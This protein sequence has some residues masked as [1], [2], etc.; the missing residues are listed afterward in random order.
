MQQRMNE[1][2]FDDLSLGEVERIE[3]DDRE[4]KTDQWAQE[5]LIPAEVWA[6]VR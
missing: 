3:T 5:A 1:A 4:A 6:E 2:F